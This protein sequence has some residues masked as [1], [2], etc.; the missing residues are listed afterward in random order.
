MVNR[1]KSKSRIGSRL[2][3]PYSGIFFSRISCSMSASGAK[4]RSHH[5]FSLSLYRE[6]K[7][8]IPRW[9]IPT[10][11][12]SGK[13][14]ARRQSTFSLSFIMLFSSPPIYCAGF[15]TSSRICSSCSRFICGPPKFGLA[16][17]IRVF[18]VY[19][20][21][22]RKSTVPPPARLVLPIFS[23]ESPACKPCFFMIPFCKKEGF[24]CCVT[25]S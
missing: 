14:N 21:L 25:I 7:I 23:S 18:L 12:L 15:C 13:Q 1:I 8:F 22:S 4:T 17:F 6:Y 10:S 5:Q 9:D 20:I 3:S 11:Y 16:F 2:S 24:G 19:M